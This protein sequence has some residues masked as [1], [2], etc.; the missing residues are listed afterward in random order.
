[1]LLRAYLCT[2]ILYLMPSSLQAGSADYL[3]NMISDGHSIRDILAYGSKFGRD[4]FAENPGSICAVG[5]CSYY[6]E[7]SILYFKYGPNGIAKG[8]YKLPKSGVSE[9]EGRNAWEILD[10]FL[11]FDPE[12]TIKWNGQVSDNFEI[13]RLLSEKKLEEALQTDN[14]RH[15]SDNH[16]AV[17][18]E[19]F[20]NNLKL[21]DSHS[22]FELSVVFPD[23][24][25]HTCAVFKESERTF[26]VMDN[27][28]VRQ[29]NIHGPISNA[30]AFQH[31]FKTK[32]PEHL[33]GVS[34]RFRW[35]TI[36]YSFSMANKLKIEGRRSK[37]CTIL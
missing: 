12:I 23:G 35:I 14:Y 28:K 37:K 10:S 13:K 24:A 33:N 11:E 8:S 36:E 3:S 32:Y 7:A 30:D 22:S 27:L 29:F 2:L 31:Y 21:M 18:N 5:R 20:T 26:F 9:K 1:M 15:L 25:I 17:D 16:T 19:A 6:T 4:F 34:K